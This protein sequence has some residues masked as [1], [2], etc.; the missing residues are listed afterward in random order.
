MTLYTCIEKRPENKD[1]T[2]TK[3][4]SSFIKTC[5]RFKEL[6]NDVEE[7]AMGSEI[8]SVADEENN[9]KESFRKPINDRGRSAIPSRT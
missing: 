6:Q 3:P 7:V 1:R 9:P 8:I 4:I 2:S 5:N